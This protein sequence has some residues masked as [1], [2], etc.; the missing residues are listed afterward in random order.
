[1]LRRGWRFD[2]VSGHVRFNTT[3]SLKKVQ[4]QDYAAM[5]SE[6]GIRRIRTQLTNWSGD[7]GVQPSFDELDLHCRHRI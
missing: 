4:E 3:K 5:V 7:I 2:E 1:M 6:G